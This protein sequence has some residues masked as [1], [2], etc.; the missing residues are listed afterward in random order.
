MKSFCTKCGQA[1]ESDAAGSQ[2]TCPACGQLTQIPGPAAGAGL[3]SPSIP[4][5]PKRK[6]S[7]TGKDLAIGIISLICL[8]LLVLLFLHPNEAARQLVYGNIGS[9]S[10]AG[11]Q[12]EPGTIGGGANG[13]PGN[14]NGASGGTGGGADGY[15]NPSGGGNSGP[16]GTSTGSA[17][18]GSSSPAGVGDGLNVASSEPGGAA[19]SPAGTGGSDWLRWRNG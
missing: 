13:T 15:S 10:P 8:V 2:I 19:S 16:G 12:S 5:A 6:F 11:G 9:K 14:E 18:A 17:G 1:I 4:A 7:P 3:E